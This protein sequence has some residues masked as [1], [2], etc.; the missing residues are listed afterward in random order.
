MTE[1][2]ARCILGWEYTGD[3]VTGFK[4]Y[5]GDVS[6]EYG[7]VPMATADPSAR[8]AEVE[9]AQ[10][11]VPVSY[12]CVVRAC[13]AVESTDSNEVRVDVEPAAPVQP[14]APTNL[15]LIIDIQMDQ[16]GNMTGMSAAQVNDAQAVEILG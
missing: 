4:V 2:S 3:E 8:T 12:F 1:S 6:G 5:C 10:A 16:S 9:F 15:R 11:Q 7:D 13:A 14:P